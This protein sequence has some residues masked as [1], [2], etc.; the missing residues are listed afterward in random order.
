M[1]IIPKQNA[2]PLVGLGAALVAPCG[3]DLT[4]A[5]AGEGRRLPCCSPGAAV[6]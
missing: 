4:A 6:N 3:R 2:R 1:P 5:S